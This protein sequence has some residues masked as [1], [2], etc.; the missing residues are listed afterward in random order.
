MNKSSYNKAAEDK[1]AEKIQEVV[2]QWT[3]TRDKV[4][5]TGA[6][7][8]RFME[9]CAKIENREQAK[10]AKKLIKNME[11][12]AKSKNRQLYTANSPR[13]EPEQSQTAAPAP[14][15]L[16]KRFDLSGVSLL[17]F[18]SFSRLS[19]CHCRSDNLL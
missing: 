8:P 5:A 4:H 15:S 6:K 13:I 7:I 18:R 16:F 17:R 2:E 19:K 3:K 1:S 14:V 9:H 11:Q 10:K 12:W